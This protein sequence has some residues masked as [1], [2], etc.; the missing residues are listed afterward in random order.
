M[1]DNFQLDNIK[2]AVSIVRTLPGPSTAVV[3]AT[4]DATVKLVDARSCNY[5]HDLKVSH[6]YNNKYTL[7]NMTNCFKYKLEI[8]HA[9]T[10]MCIEISLLYKIDVSCRH[11]KLISN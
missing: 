9:V 5:T 7:E 2:S 4:T 6:L 10:V 8:N 11:F 1:F 3:C